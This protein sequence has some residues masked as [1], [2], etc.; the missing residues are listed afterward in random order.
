MTKK[1]ID[2]YE[3]HRN[4]KSAADELGIKWQ[5]LY[6]Q[7]RKLGVK[8]V[9][10]KLRY[11]SDKDRFAARAELEFLRLVHFAENQNSVSYQSK[12]DYLVCG[13]KVDIKASNAAQGSK[14]FTATRWAFSVKKQEFCADFIVCFAMIDSGYRIFL[15]PG[16]LVRKYQTISISTNP[17]SKSKWLQYEIQ[18]DDL[19]EFFLQLSAI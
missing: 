2:A 4:L 10:D 18:P 16:E 17:S 15:I 19:T 7:L 9:G 8:V 6:V 5:S 14:N 12:F 3:K 13:E 1:L 11:G